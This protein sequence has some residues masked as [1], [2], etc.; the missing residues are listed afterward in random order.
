MFFCH[1]HLTSTITSSTS[2]QQSSSSHVMLALSAVK[3]IK[4]GLLVNLLKV[5]LY[6]LTC[7]SAAL[8]ISVLLHMKMP[9]IMLF[10]KAHVKI[11]LR[12]VHREMSQQKVEMVAEQWS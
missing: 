1:C 5:I 9:K 10:K 8:Q 11:H 7:F 2:M 3:D 6:K 12:T 4:A